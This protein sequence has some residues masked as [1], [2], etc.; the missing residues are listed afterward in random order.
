MSRLGRRVRLLLGLSALALAAAVLFFGLTAPRRISAAEL[1]AHRPDA[2]NGEYLFH[3]G[4]CAACHAAPGKEQTA[5]TTLA[6]GLELNSPFGSFVVPNISPDPDDGIGKWSTVDFV[7]AMKFGTR[8]DGEHLYPAFPYTSF[9]HMTDADLID[10]KAYLDTLP[11]VRGKPP[12]HRLFFP[13]NIRRGVGL[14]D[15]LYANDAGFMPRPGEDAATARGEYLVTGPGHC[16]ECHT[17]RNLIGGPI[18]SQALSGAA[19]PTGGGVALNLTQ[20]PDALGSWS[21]DDIVDLIQF[22]ATPDGRVLGPVMAE[23]IDQLRQL[24][25]DDQQAIAAYLKSLPAIASPYV[26]KPA[27]N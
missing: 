18:T 6:G 21:T 10:L 26:R 13:F 25:P 23:V 20:A 5:P 15:R 9:Q 4:G 1:P 14:W 16:G 3:I 22:G 8:P 2:K 17:P 12:P 19:L 27:Q 11:K 7:N 24:T